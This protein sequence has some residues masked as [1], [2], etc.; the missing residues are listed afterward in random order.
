MVGVDVGVH[1]ERAALAKR[2]ATH[3]AM[4]WPNAGVRQQV[5][6]VD[7]AQ[8]ERLAAFVAAKGS[9]AAVNGAH[10]HI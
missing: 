2:V 6:F 4:V 7:L 8:L 5:L 1:L 3:I 10:V 9:M